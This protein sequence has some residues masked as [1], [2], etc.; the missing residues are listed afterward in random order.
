VLLANLRADLQRVEPEDRPRAEELLARLA[1]ARAAA[2]R[3]LREA[4]RSERCAKLLED[5][6]RLVASPPF[7]SGDAERPA[8]KIVPTLVR[9]PL[10]RCGARPSSSVRAWTMPSFI[11]CGSSANACATP[12]T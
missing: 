10:R 5:V 8:G 11:A 1:D 3:E 6:A 4:I 2:Y 9:R 7:A 12:P